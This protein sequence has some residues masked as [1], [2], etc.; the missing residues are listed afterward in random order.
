M[1]LDNNPPCQSECH[2]RF[3][4]HLTDR[5]TIDSQFVI[6]RSVIRQAVSQLTDELSY[7]FQ[8]KADGW[9][10]GEGGG[11]RRPQP[12]PKN[13]SLDKTS[14]RDI[15]ATLGQF[16]NKPMADAEDTRAVGGVA[17]TERLCSKLVVYGV[18]MVTPDGLA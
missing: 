3:V 13:A 4:R 10:N 18:D 9:A 12:Q 16:P 2:L 6:L 17:E 15:K 11:R 5:L 1:S 7:D 14:F 8:K